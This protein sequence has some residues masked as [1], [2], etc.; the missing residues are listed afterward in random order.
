MTDAD[1]EAV[2]EIRVRGWQYAYAGLMPKPFLDAMSVE[3]ETVRRRAYLTEPTPGVLNLVAE[4]AGR[5]VGWGCSGPC[6]DEDVPAGTAEVY[7]L[8]VRPDRI[9]TGVGRALMD[10]LTAAAGEAGHGA[11]VLWVLKENDRAR[12]F[13]TRSGLAPDGAEEPFDVAG[14]H[15]PEVRYT[16]HLTPPSA[17]G[18]SD[19]PGPPGSSSPSGV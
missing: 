6:R 9:A 1:C 15:V 11:L 19:F 14:T 2:A 16:R 4:H 8:Y 7:A 10:A 18:P 5:V 13:Y 17:P 12:R 3:K